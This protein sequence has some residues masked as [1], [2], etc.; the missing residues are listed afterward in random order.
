MTLRLHKVTKQI[1]QL[2]ENAVAR[3]TQQRKDLPKV[4]KFFRQAAELNDLP[5]KARLAAEKLK[6][7]GAMPAGE[8][9]SFI[10]AAPSAPSALA[11]VAVDGSQVYPDSHEASLFYAIN[12][13]YFIMR[14]G[15][16]NTTADSEP[17]I[18]F[19]EDSLFPG[20]H[21]IPRTAID[22]RRTVEEMAT[23][24]RL[25]SAERA[26]AP[27]TPVFALAD[28]TLTLWIDEKGVQPT[29]RDAL[30]RKYFDSIKRL[31]DERIPIAGY[32]ARPSRFP[33]L[34]LI[35]LA[36]SPA[37][38][39]A[40]ERSR[41][42]RSPFPGLDDRILF[43]KI[44]PAGHRSAVF[45]FAS[46]LNNQYRSCEPNQ[47]VHFFYLNVGKRYP[48]ITRVEIPEWTAK[49]PTLMDLVH[50]VL[51][52]QCSVTLNDP[53]PYALIRADEEAFVSGKDT[54]Y[55]E[56]QMAV[57]LIRSGLRSSRSEKLSHKGRARKH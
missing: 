36:L 41:S 15:T 47:S 23:L 9:I 3:A 4:E 56:Q 16:G 31:A 26:A 17:A 46:D 30:Q 7:N 14:F 57:S 40:A 19:E 22:A 33:V 27:S 24:E 20:G 45:E 25:A 48:V 53:Y 11:L 55:L 44:L 18:F 1:D 35:D 42:G 5:Q 43:E 34:H 54:K 28:G 38:E 21:L 6:W 51:I 37:P 13:G 39:P 2:R 29:E 49:D 12:I 52:E 8:A 10:K 32:V 50:G